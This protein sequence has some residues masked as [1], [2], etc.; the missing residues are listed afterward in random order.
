MTYPG[1]SLQ[2]TRG[3][4]RCGKGEDGVCV[5]VCVWGGGGGENSLLDKDCSLG[6]VKTCL[7][8]SLEKVRGRGMERRREGEKDREGEH[9][10]RD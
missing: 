3:G 8:T 1:R 9:R 2:C 10:E 5:C 6:E 4:V 7:T